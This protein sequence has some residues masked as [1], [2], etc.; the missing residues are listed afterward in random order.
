M[1]LA[2]LMENYSTPSL[3]RICVAELVVGKGL[4]KT[5][6]THAETCEDI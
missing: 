4:R 5:D 3:C 2:K 6:R 1:A